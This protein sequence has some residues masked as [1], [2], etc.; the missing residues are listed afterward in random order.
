MAD[1]VTVDNGGLTDYVTATN[2]L[3]A[4]A[5]GTIAED[6]AISGNPVRVGVRGSSAVP[7]AMSSVSGETV[8]LPPAPRLMWPGGSGALLTVLT[9]A[10]GGPESRASVFAIS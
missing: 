4:T 6:A 1:N 3:P 10:G 9:G 2:P 7:T 5:V 8:N